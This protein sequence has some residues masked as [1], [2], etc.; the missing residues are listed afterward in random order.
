MRAERRVP[1]PGRSRSAGRHRSRDPSWE[2]RRRGARHPPSRPGPIETPIPKSEV[3][4]SCEDLLIFRRDFS[5]DD[6]PDRATSKQNCARL[7]VLPQANH[8]KQKVILAIL[9]CF[10]PGERV[11]PSNGTQRRTR[12]QP[13]RWTREMPALPYS[14]RR[15]GP[16]RAVAA[17]GLPTAPPVSHRSPRGGGPA[18]EAGS[19]G[20]VLVPWALRSPATQFRQTDAVDPNLVAPNPHLRTPR[21]TKP[22]VATADLT[23]RETH[24]AKRRVVVIRSTHIRRGVRNSVRWP[25]TLLIP[26]MKLPNRLR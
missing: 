11:S 9:G 8:V 5:E 15:P 19:H 14:R 4:S 20:M 10:F 6:P 26:F 23:H 3:F 13:M 12:G 18:T 1:T 17:V 25:T 16:R 24:N 21:D 22:A 2:I 7:S